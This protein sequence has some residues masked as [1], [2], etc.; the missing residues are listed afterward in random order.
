[1]QGLR[2]LNFDVTDLAGARDFYT[3]VLGHG[4][5]FDEPF[6]VGFDVEGYELGLRPVEAGRGQ[7]SATAYLGTH[8]V[9]AEVARLVTL[10][11]TV[12][13]KPED[14]GGGIRVATL[15][16]PFG[17]AL[18]LIS[19]PE[20]APKLVAAGAGDLSERVIAHGITVPLPRGRVW[21]LWTSS[22]GLM[23]WL[24]DQAKV[25]LRV[26]G[27]YEVYFMNE[28][29]TG[30]RGSE[31]CRVLSFVPGR[32]VSFTWNAP[33]HLDKTRFQHTWVVV[34]LDD[35]GAGTKVEVT[36]TGWPASGLKNE[37]QW[38]QT[39]AY[40]DRAWQG[41]LKSL[42]HFARTGQKAS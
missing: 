12:R 18:G 6:Y 14:V 27:A 34:E 21:E 17:N 19:N 5:Y 2:T 23:S 20:F 16:D 13:E 8:D 36:H 33:P 31:T 1:M 10:G 37:P 35:E 22:A 11:A 28:A 7:G 38:E 32:M 30:S 26:G 4:P 15:I 42:E 40:F 25:E 24:V 39:F 41:V 9:D 3:K 29:R